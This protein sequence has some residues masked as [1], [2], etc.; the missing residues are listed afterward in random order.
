MCVTLLPLCFRLSSFVGR[1][2][3]A[4]EC[5]SGEVLQEQAVRVDVSSSLGNSV[6]GIKFVSSW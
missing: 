6:V 3:L 5:I 2:R 4:T 1:A